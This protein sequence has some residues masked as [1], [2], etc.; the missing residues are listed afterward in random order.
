MRKSWKDVEYQMEKFGLS[1]EEA[2][3]KIEEIKKNKPNPYSVNY[4]MSKFKLTENEA[5]AKIN[6]LKNKTAT[7]KLTTDPHWQMQRFGLTYDEAV[8]KISDSYNKR[9]KKI[10]KTKKD[11]PSTHF[12]T[13]EYWMG[14]GFNEKDAIKRKKEH[15]E[16]MHNVF[17]SKI[18]NEPEFYKG[19]TPLE[20]EYWTNKGFTE[21][22]AKQKVKERQKTFTLEKCIQKYGP[23]IGPNV[24]KDRH[25]NWSKK[26]EQKYKSGEFSRIC[27]TI[28]SSIELDLIQNIVNRLNTNEKYYCSLNGQKQ[29]FRFFSSVEKC[30]A[31]D[32]VIGKKIIEFNGDFWHCNPKIYEP[33]HYHPMI[34][35]TA[36]EIWDA[37]QEKIELITGCGYDVLVVWESDYRKNPEEV[38]QS[39][40]DFLKTI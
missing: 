4:Q 29:Y 33:T 3:L 6:E 30:F 31:Y 21:V 17:V 32:F 14:K 24:W 28:Y 20:I 39:C 35:K 16:S 18:K 27:K 15:I 37:H 22:E 38:I 8:K 9:G 2:L 13:V 23:E 36:K 7:A 12:N 1:R 34:K 26:V 11:D 5:V 19:R 10:S 25:T 40:I